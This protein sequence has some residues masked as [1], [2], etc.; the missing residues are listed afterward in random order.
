MRALVGL[1]LG[2]H[3]TSTIRD[4]PRG[5]RSRAHYR[6]ISMPRRVGWRRAEGPP[7]VLLLQPRPCLRFAE[8][9]QH[10]ALHAQRI[11]GN[12]AGTAIGLVV[13]GIGDVAGIAVFP[14]RKA[15]RSVCPHVCRSS[16]SRKRPRRRGRS[17]RFRRSPSSSCPRLPLRQKGKVAAHHQGSSNHQYAFHKNSSKFAQTLLNR[18]GHEEMDAH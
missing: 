11:A 3:D 18:T 15:C 6:Q 4:V 2:G 5:I 13:G 7:A 1:R 9:L 16:A 8:N 12:G 14:C 10:A 17:R